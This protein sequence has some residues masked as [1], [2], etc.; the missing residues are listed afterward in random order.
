MLFVSIGNNVALRCKIFYLV[1][2]FKI[3]KFFLDEGK[4]RLE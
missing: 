2:L 1:V 4:W 3:V